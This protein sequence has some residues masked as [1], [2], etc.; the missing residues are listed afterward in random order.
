MF[1]FTVWVRQ[2]QI[3]RQHKINHVVNNA[4]VTKDIL[5]KYVDI[6]S[7]RIKTT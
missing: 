7:K 5:T 2:I 3:K 4:F 1:A 6:F